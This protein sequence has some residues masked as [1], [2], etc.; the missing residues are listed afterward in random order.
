MEEI[1]KLRRKI[2]TLEAENNSLNI[3]ETTLSEVI[4]NLRSRQIRIGARK[5]EIKN[6]ISDIREEIRM[7][8]KATAQAQPV[9]DPDND[10][11]SN[12][13]LKK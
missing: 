8:K 13:N 9:T 10:N 3:K 7:M 6:E 1:K 11:N 5:M 2:E 12:N 4:A